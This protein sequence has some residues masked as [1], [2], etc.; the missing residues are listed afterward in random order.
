MTQPWHRLF[1][2]ATSPKLS[3]GSSSIADASSIANTESTISPETMRVAVA[4]RATLAALGYQPYDPFPGG[5]G[6]P[7]GLNVTVRLFVAPPQD[8]QIAVM[9]KIPEEVL[10]SLSQQWGG[11]ALLGWLTEEDG[12]FAVYHNGQR[13]DSATA[14]APFLRPEQ[15]LT[16]L[17]RALAGEIE[18][19]PLDETPGGSLPPELQTLA[20]DRGVD[21]EHASSLFERLSGGLFSKLDKRGEGSADQEQARVIFSGG[22]HD[23]WNTLQGQRVR[24]IADTLT[25]PGNWRLPALETV[26]DAYQVHRLRQRNP[27]M[28]LII[29]GDAELLRSLPDALSYEPVYMGHA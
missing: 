6:T 5:T 22:E 21:T 7:L 25:L 18:V 11:I 13:S 17:H 26:R 20:E 28:P 19:L 10:S 12:G 29:P 16:T 8:G 24:A 15:N 2:P 23:L 3:A 14:L 4:L 1:L 9:G 27:R